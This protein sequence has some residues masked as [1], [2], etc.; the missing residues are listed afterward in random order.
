[1]NTIFLPIK[2]KPGLNARE[3]WWERSRRAK[4]E[5][6]AA[7][8]AFGATLRHG[9]LLPCTIT[10]VR[11]SAAT[12]DDDNLPGAFKAIR[13]GIADALGVKDNNPAVTWRYDQRKCKRG[14][15]GIVIEVAK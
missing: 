9:T 3:H 6:Q 7:K 4:S 5:R 8:L 11:L 1:M 2:T 14:E 10:L 13:D 15:F 12:M